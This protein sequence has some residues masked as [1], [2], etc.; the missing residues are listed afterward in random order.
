MYNLLDFPWVQTIVSFFSVLK[1]TT[2]TKV[3][4]NPFLFPSSSFLY[5]HEYFVEFTADSIYPFSFPDYMKF[6]YLSSSFASYVSLVSYPRIIFLNSSV[7]NVL[8]I[9]FGNLHTIK[10]SMQ[11]LSLQNEKFLFGSSIYF[12]ENFNS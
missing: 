6:F 8:N 12:I 4:N 9:L 11:L 2:N 10:R 3:T 5:T 1:C 7:L